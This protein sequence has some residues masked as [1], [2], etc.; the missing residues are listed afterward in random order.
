MSD[1]RKGSDREQNAD[2]DL[3]HELEA[4]P[5]SSPGFRVP[6]QSIANPR[7]PVFDSVLVKIACHLVYTFDEHQVLIRAL[8]GARRGRGPT[9]AVAFVPVRPTSYPWTAST[10]ANASQVDLCAHC[11]DLRWR[12]CEEV[13]RVAALRAS[14]SRGSR[15]AD[16]AIVCILIITVVV[17]VCCR[18]VLG[19]GAYADEDQ[20]SV[21][22]DRRRRA[23]ERD[24]HLP[25]QLQRQ[26]K[27][28]CDVCVDG[29]ACRIH[30]RELAVH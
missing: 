10:A 30:L 24:E 1:E 5:E 26:P 12:R 18:G 14:A 19:C 25:H 20:G 28:R 7:P 13:G 22:Q 29:S 3:R 16:G 2:R 15:N 6:E 27:Q 21:L 4:A 23:D 8:W 9:Q 11:D 17:N